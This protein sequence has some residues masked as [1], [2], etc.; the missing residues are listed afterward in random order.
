MS[1]GVSNEKPHFGN[2]IK[3]AGVIGSAFGKKVGKDWT[4]S[5]SSHSHE[6]F[7][8]NSYSKTTTKSSTS[9]GVHADTGQLI[10]AG[11]SVLGSIVNEMKD[12]K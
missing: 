12:S 1:S 5:K 4:V 2:A 6:S 10:Q 3:E 9:V 7:S 11:A 8:G